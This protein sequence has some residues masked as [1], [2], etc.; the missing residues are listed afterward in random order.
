MERKKKK[1]RQCQ[2]QRRWMFSNEGILDTLKGPERTCSH[3]HTEL[4]ISLTQ[5][6]LKTFSRSRAVVAFNPSTWEAETGRFPSSRPAWSTKWVPGQPG[7]HL[8]RKNQKPKQ[9]KK[10][11]S[12]IFD[13]FRKLCISGQCNRWSLQWLVVIRKLSFQ[14]K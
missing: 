14:G 10:K 3:C 13:S 9:N 1:K 4:G 7:L 11:F 8:S 6:S 5:P 2:G 12:I